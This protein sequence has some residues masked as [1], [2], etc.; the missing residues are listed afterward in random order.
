MVAFAGAYNAWVRR[1]LWRVRRNPGGLDVKE[2]TAFDLA[3]RAWARLKRCVKKY[4][5]GPY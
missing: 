5:V 1:F 3:D 2:A 4:Y